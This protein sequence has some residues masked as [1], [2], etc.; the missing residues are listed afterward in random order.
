MLICDTIFPQYIDDKAY[1]IPSKSK[2][3]HSGAT[4]NWIRLQNEKVDGYQLVWFKGL[5]LG[6]V[7]FVGLLSWIGFQQEQ[8]NTSKVLQLVLAALFVCLEKPEII[9]SLNVASLHCFG[10]QFL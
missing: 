6:I 9:F 2:E 1:W 10:V 5:F 7:S 3:F 8:D 4:W